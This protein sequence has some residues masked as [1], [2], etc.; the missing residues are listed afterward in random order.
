MTIDQ[1]FDNSTA[2]Y[3]SWVKHALPCYNEIFIT[4]TQ[5]MPFERDTPIK[6]LDLGAG[7]GLFSEHVLKAFPNGTFVLWD[8]AKNMLGVA[9]KR[10][11]EHG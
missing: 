2:T 10:F 1:V 3:D 11:Q 7:T 8:L 4:A 5:V 9:R 6:V